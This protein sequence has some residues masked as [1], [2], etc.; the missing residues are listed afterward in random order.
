L[1]FGPGLQLLGKAKNGAHAVGQV[2]VA[3]GLH[4][5]KQRLGGIVFAARVKQKAK[6]GRRQQIVGSLL[7]QDAE[8]LLGRRLQFHAKQEIGQLAAEFQIALVQLERG[9]KFRD[10]RVAVGQ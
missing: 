1:R 3:A 10:E 7:H 4:A 8:L 5:V 2:V 6:L 9:L